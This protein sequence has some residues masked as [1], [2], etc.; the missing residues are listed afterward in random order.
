MH[1]HMH[2]YN[3]HKEEMLGKITV[4]IFVTGHAVVGGKGNTE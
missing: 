2:T 1:K 4:L 3:E